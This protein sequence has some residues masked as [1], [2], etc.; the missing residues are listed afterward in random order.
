MRITQLI[1]ADIDAIVNSALKQVEEIKN[2]TLDPKQYTSR[3]PQL[4]EPRIFDRIKLIPGKEEDIDTW[5]T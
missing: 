1:K 4:M 2:G 3:K 5:G